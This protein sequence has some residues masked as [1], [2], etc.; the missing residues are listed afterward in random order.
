MPLLGS[1]ADTAEAKELS[2]A[3]A[4]EEQQSLE[5]FQEWRVLRF[6]EETRQSVARVTVAVGADGSTVL[7]QRPDCMAFLYMKTMASAGKCMLS[8]YCRTIHFLLQQ[9]LFCSS[10]FN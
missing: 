7:T 9:C 10:N 5:R 6:N 2:R 8:H 3:E 1:A 4:A